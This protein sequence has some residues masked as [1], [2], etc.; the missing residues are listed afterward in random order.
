MDCPTCESLVDAYVDGELSATDSADFEHALEACPECRKRLEAARSMSAMLRELPLEPAPDLL[1]ARIDRE[2][3]AIA[4]AAAPR[5]ALPR[6]TMPVAMAASLLVAAC[7]G[8]VGGTLTGR[9]GV[10][11]DEMV[12]TY[13]RVASSEHAV[14]VASSDRHTVKPWFA[15]RIDYS[16]PVRDLTSAGFPL[17]GGRIDVVDGRKVSV[18]VY[19][20]N[21]HRVALSLWPAAEPGDTSPRVT[22]YNGFSL[23]TWRHG[24]F[25]MHAA[26]DVAPSEMADFAAALDRDTGEDR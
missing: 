26:S 16:P 11:E 9:G 25:E 6:W 15:G 20:H 3:R 22:S 13:L 1:H 12:S 21:Q 23:A 24:G 10:G 2:L 18:L 5:R 8:W 14:D 17:E 7:I 4:G 19:R